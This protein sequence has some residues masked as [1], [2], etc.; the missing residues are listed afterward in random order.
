MALTRIKIEYTSGKSDETVYVEQSEFRQF[1]EVWKKRKNGKGEAT[2]TL[3][4][5][6]TQGDSERKK[7]IGL[8]G[9][10]SIEEME[11]PSQPGGFTLTGE[12][13]DEDDGPITFKE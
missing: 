8:D 5:R 4:Y 11:Q 7:S 10:A 13:D 3:H 12:S 2:T 6:K 9:I 1:Q